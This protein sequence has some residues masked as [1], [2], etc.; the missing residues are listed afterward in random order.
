M[1][2]LEGQL[3]RRH[4]ISSF[5]VSERTGPVTGIQQHQCYAGVFIKQSSQVQRADA[6]RAAA[7]D[8]PCVGVGCGPVQQAAHE[9]GAAGT[10]RTVK[11][12][13]AI[14]QEVM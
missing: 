2:H 12:G 3:E 6:G 10:H 7:R 11:Q 4:S 9:A 8:A 14:L 5:C 13:Q 1:P